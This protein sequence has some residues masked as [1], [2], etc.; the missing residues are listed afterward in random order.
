MYE[1]YYLHWA[2]HHFQRVPKNEPYDSNAV[3]QLMSPLPNQGYRL[4]EQFTSFIQSSLELAKEIH[5]LI[6]NSAYQ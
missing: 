3:L 4:E 5:L 2:G 6:Q 1:F